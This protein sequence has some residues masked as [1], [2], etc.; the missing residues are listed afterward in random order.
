MSAPGFVA[1][2]CAYRGATGMI[3]GPPIPFEPSSQLAGSGDRSARHDL[4]DGG[5]VRQL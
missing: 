2:A 5:I 1:I 3:G 4:G